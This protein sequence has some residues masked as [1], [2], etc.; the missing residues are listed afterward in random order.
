MSLP[1]ATFLHFG[2]SFHDAPYI[3]LQSDFI[4]LTVVCDILNALFHCDI[5]SASLRTC[6]CS[7]IIVALHRTMG[8]LPLHYWHHLPWCF[9]DELVCC[10]Q[11]RLVNSGTMEWSHSQILWFICFRHSSAFLSF[12]LPTLRSVISFVNVT[13]WQR[14]QTGHGWWPWLCS[15]AKAL[16]LWYAY[17]HSGDSIAMTCA[18]FTVF[19]VHF[20][21][22]ISFWLAHSDTNIQFISLFIHVLPM[23]WLVF[24][25]Y[26][27]DNDCQCYDRPYSC[28][29]LLCHHQ[30]RTLPL[31]AW[32]SQDHLMA[33]LFI[34]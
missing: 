22:C 17:L 32:L 12:W 20:L 33:T 29:F 27:I 19:V 2:A 18:G 23:L 13:G 15:I 16:L 14:Y 3:L 9:L 21:H 25:S 34:S 30:G 8:S 6:C 1:W 26:V 5:L 28:C 24:S 4:A 11:L 10:G 7:L 31:S